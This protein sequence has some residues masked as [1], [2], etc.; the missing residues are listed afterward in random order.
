MQ[1]ALK[2]LQ[3]IDEILQL[4]EEVAD[5]SGMLLD[6]LDSVTESLGRSVTDRYQTNDC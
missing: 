4:V 1:N 5:L 3:Y 6:A 2:L